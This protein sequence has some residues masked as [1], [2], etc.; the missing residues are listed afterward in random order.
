MKK[1]ILCFILLPFIVC[2]Q[3]DDFSYFPYKSSLIKYLKPSQKSFNLD[4]N[5]TDHSTLEYRSFSSKGQFIAV[6][7]QQK[8]TDFIL[9]NL[10]F[11]KFSQEG[12]FNREALN[13]YDVQ[14]NLFFK[15]KKQN[16]FINLKLGYSK[17][18]MDENGGL[19]NY[20]T[21]DYDDALLFPV[22]LLSAENKVKTR[23]H[24]IAQNLIFTD[25]W[26]VA[27][28]FAILSN[29]R[30]YSDLSPNSGYY[31]SIFIDSTSTF[32]SL[33]TLDYKSIFSVN[34]NSFSINQLSYM[35][36]AYIHSIDTTDN[37][38]G[39]GFS[40]NLPEKKF[41]F[42]SEFYQSTHY[43][44]SLLKT[45]TGINSSHTIDISLNKLRVPIF[46]NSYTSNHYRFFNQ[47]DLEQYQSFNYIWKFNWGSISTQ[48]NRIVDYIYLDQSASFQQSI[49]PVL[50]SINTLSYKGNLSKFHFF[51]KLQYQLTDNKILR[52]PKVNSNTSIWYET[53]LF[54]YKLN[55][56]LGAKLNYFS[57]YFANAYNPTLA[58]FQLQDIHAI[59]ESPFVSTFLNLKFH[60]FSIALEYNN[61]GNLFD[62]RTPYFIPN[63][64]TYPST[65]RL[66]I[67][68]KLSNF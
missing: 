41:S 50:Q 52:L 64:P 59:G 27:H 51:Q 63:Y 24:L 20:K 28:K 30:I 13:L 4:T 34:Y 11:H 40:F 56:K 31:Q 2:A 14:S 25:K 21:N 68:W 19:S 57:S 12:I 42:N 67:L 49:T 22:N 66:S 43:T 39:F 65:I 17:I 23:N 9:F 32:D 48:L 47:F 46:T 3:H 1:Y 45:F 54:D 16:Y 58:T 29:R 18:R 10:N 8:I 38:L 61:L 62:L 55:T 44:I 35:R 37:D 53:N 6:E 36:K 33:S 26:S 7:H 15:N 60:D 5:K